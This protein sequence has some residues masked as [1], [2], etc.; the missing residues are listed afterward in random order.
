M[1][2]RD[3]MH[4]QDMRNLII[5]A[6]LSISMWLGYDLLI[7]RPHAEAMRAAALQARVTAERSAPADIL[8]TAVVKPREEVVSS[9]NRIA[10]ETPTMSGSL[11]LK[12]ARLDDIRLKDYFKTIEKKE[13]VALLSPAQTPHPRYV[14]SGWV[15]D[16]N[17]TSVPDDDTIWRVKEGGKLTPSTPV[18]LTHT[19]AQGVVFEKTFRV[20]N[21]FAFKIESRVVN[22]SGKPITLYPYALATEHGL[23]EDFANTGIIHEGP[24]GY[25]GEKLHEKDYKD[26]KKRPEEN[27]NGSSGW[28]G[29]TSKYWL[30]AIAPAGQEA[31]SKFRF[32]SSPAI[33]EKTKDRFQADFTGAAQEV[34]P[35]AETTYAVNVFSGPKKLKLLEKYEDEWAVP[36][37]D[38]AVDFGWFYFLT[39]PFFLALNFLYGLTGNFGIAIIIF[40]CVLRVFVFPLANTSYRSF[41]KLRQVSPEMYNLR[42]EYKDNKQ[43]LQEELVKL[44]QKHNVNPAAGCLPILVQ[45]PI[46][47]ALYKVLSNTIEM[48]H[49]PFFGWIE[50]LSVKDPTSIFN[51][52]GLLPYDVPSFLIIGIWPC[53]MLVAMIVQKNISP[54]PDDPIQARVIALMPWLMTYIMAGFAAGL[55]IYWT[56]NNVLAILQQIIIMRSMGVPIHLFSKDKDKERLEKEI[57][58]GPMVS[59]TLELLEEKAE[60]ALHLDEPK[61]VTPPKGKKKKKK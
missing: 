27:M 57:E 16:K 23:P 1:Q 5:F 10:I 38:L 49:A 32:V 44:Y 45:I 43:K 9:G 47:F 13:Q 14:E 56:V 15:S 11:N 18:T 42:H 7:A 21:D 40:T 37:F 31:E 51:L 55:V 30:T 29:L 4:P 41:A 33:N 46:F 53:L 61:D 19:N 52:F 26:F 35:G 50:D 59:P 24:I 17:A 8:E 60:H 54:P 3:Q 36:H 39:K 34:A 6:V 12:G 48:R 28:V 25:I 20:D 22:R 58:E 2:S